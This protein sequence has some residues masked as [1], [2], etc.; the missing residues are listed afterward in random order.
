MRQV[1]AVTQVINNS[2]QLLHGDLDDSID[3]EL[4]FNLTG[5]SFY[6]LFFLELLV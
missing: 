3:E 1:G 5:L 4:A 6:G 2:P